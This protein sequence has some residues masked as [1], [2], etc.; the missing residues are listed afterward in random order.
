M[1]TDTDQVVAAL[2][3]SLLDNQ[4]LRQENRRLRDDSA[5]PVAVVAMSCRYPGGVRTPEDLWELLVKE[6]DAVSPFPTDRGWDV[7]GGFDADPDAPGTFYVREGG[8]LHD[9]TGFDPG[10]FGISPREALAMDPQQRLLLEASWEAVERAGIDPTTL[11]GSRTG[12]YTGVIY[13]EY[14]SRLDRVPD[15]VEGFLGTGSIPSVASGRIAYT[16]G[17]EGP[18]VT[19]DTAC[20]SSLVAVH[21]A[22]QGLRSGDT[23]LALAGGVTV[24]STPGL[25]V[26][27]SR[28]R[29][30]APDGRSKSFSSAADGAGFGEGLGLL[31]LERLSD[32][33]RAG[34]PVLAVIRGSA[35][36]QDGASNGLT[37]PNGPAQQRVISQALARAGLAPSEVDMV[38]AHGTGTVLGDPIEAQ[39]L[40]ATYGQDRPAGRPLWLG[41]LKSNLSHTQAAAG[42]GGVIKSVLAMRHGVMPRTLHVDRPS[43]RVDWTEGAVSLLTE[44]TPWPETGRPRRAGVSSFGASGTNAHVILEQAPIAPVVLEETPTAPTGATAAADKPVDRTDTPEPVPAAVPWILSARTPDALRAQAA[45][46]HERVVAEPGLSVVDVGHSLAVGRSRFAERAVV[47]GADR[48]E[49]LAGLAALSRGAGSAGVVTGGGPLPGR[50]VLVFPGHGSQWVGMAAGL[51]GESDVFAERMAECGRALAPYTDWSLAEALGSERLLA[52]VDVVQPVLWAVMVS[53]AEVWRAFGVVPDAVVGH[54]Q[55]EIAAA[56]V[57]GGLS[58][59]DGAR[60][61]AL[62]SRAV[63]ALAGR[64]GMASVPLPVDVVRERTAP[65]AG[66]LSVAAVNGPSSTVV[67]GAADAVTAL[68][69]ELLEEGV[70][71]APIDVDYASHSIHVEEIRERLLSDLEGITPLSGAVP[72]YSSVTGGPLDTKALDAGYWYRNLRQTVEFERATRSLLAAG[73][74]VFIES[75][76]QPALMYGIEDTAADAGAPETLVLDTLRRGAG[77][78]RRFQTALAEAHVRG[79]RVDWERLFAG[80]GARRVDLPTYAFQRRRYWLDALP[81]DRDPAATGQLA[82]DHPLLGAEVELPDDAGSLFTGRLSLATHPWLADHAVAGAVIVPGAALVE[83]AAYVGRRLGCALVEELT[84]AAPLSLPGDA[85][86]DH[87][88]HLRVR[89]GAE[90]GAGR[91]PVEFHSRPEAAPGAAAPP[92]TRHATGTVGPQEPSADGDDTAGP[93]GAWPPPDAVP[94]DVDELYGLLEARGVAYGPAFRGLRAAW[95][96]TDAIHAEVALPDDLPGTGADGFAMH[97]ALLDAAL[98][99]AGLREVAGTAQTA[100]GVPLPFSW[101]RVAIGTS[102]APVLR[103]RLRP[104]GPDTVAARITDPSG[105]TVATVGSLT[106]RTASTAALRA[107]SGSVFHVG[108]TPVTA[109]PGPRP[110]TRWGLL[111]PRDERLLPVAFPADLLPATPDAMLLPCPPSAGTGTTDGATGDTPARDADP[112]AA[113]VVVSGVLD[114]VQAHLA[115]DSTARTPLVVLTRGATGPLGARPQ[116]A[117]LG[118]AAVWGMLRAAQLEHPDRFVLLDT[119]GPDPD[120]LGDALADLLATGE[121][122]AALRGGVLYAPRLTRPSPTT[123][124]TAPATAAR[125]AGPFGPSEGTVLLSGGGA[126]AAVLARHLV[127]AHGV[128]HLLVLSRRG[129]DAPGIPELT[130][131]LAEAGAELTAVS[132]DVAD[133]QALA[134]ALAAVP[135]RHPLRAVVHTAGVLDDGLLDGL[136]A[137][138]MSAV[139]RPKLDAA[140]HLDQLTRG[141]DLSAFV[142]FS[143]AAA[144]LGSPG[145]ASYSA[146]NAALDALAAERRRLGLPGLSLAW[147]PWERVGGMT[148]EL[149]GAERRRIDRRGARGLVDEEAMALLDTVC[150]PDAAPPGDGSPVVL[151]HLDLTVRGDGPVHPMLRS[152]VR[153]GPAATTGAKGTPTAAAALRNRLDAAADAEEHE[154]VLREL[155]LAQ[156][157]EVLG[158]T[159]SGALSATVPFLSVGF[160]SLTAVELRNRLAA[161]TGL[162]LRPSA[163]FDSGTPAALAARLATEARTEDTPRP[164]TAPATGAASGTGTADTDPVSVLF[165]R[166]CALGRID[167]GIALLK[168]A[169][170]LRPSFHSGGD[171]AAAGTGPRLLRL[172]ERA[173]APVLVCFG[174]VVA[175]GGAHQ[176]AR[177]AS[178][179]RDRYAVAALDAPGFTPEEELPADM[180]A[181]LDF[182]ATTL[183]RELPGRTLV[184]V[185][186]SSGGTLAHGV[187]AALEQRG[188]GPAAV[189]LLDTYLSDNQGITQFNDVLLGGMFAREDRAAPMDGTRLTAMG[190]YFRLLDDWNPPEV[191]APLLLVRASTPLGR[192][193]AEAGDWRSSWAGADAVVDVPGDHFSIMEQHVATTG[194]AVADWLGTTLRTSDD[195]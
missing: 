138:R 111:G 61:V 115:D 48:G 12:V 170:A 14:A 84:L 160:D 39:A 98:Q 68:V 154:L 146:A 176:Y 175:L 58:L 186:S 25:Y 101:Q 33:R 192:P 4:R 128:R 183:L 3:A 191:R 22:C 104:D 5:E 74:R 7:E 37:A 29:G 108:W 117:D 76:P 30:L 45:V 13:G 103:V 85:A 57:A 193:S 119:E 21:L 133:R 54:S 73:H 62:R 16:L 41:S 81:A 194:D 136:T 149:G 124:A 177:F 46:L 143:S 151:A 140:R 134:A 60:V 71:A 35:V 163:V 66:R 63:G 139:L 162:R 44:A 6:R 157:A 153:R 167:E 56:C 99:T 53:L 70:W 179:F 159:D 65:W 89:V 27:F 38:E 166:A 55:G 43:P 131:E 109:G 36:N 15:E 156:A 11:R 142:V 93:A 83:L 152:L 51:L 178:R 59:D 97:P 127:A 165:R 28:Q 122:Q 184:L 137:E 72:Y 118:A 88:V 195:L 107:S 182:Q 2:R 9:A 105:R 168:H 116:P 79:L 42:V 144:V 102:D 110:V 190:G 86:D 173:D 52:R 17:L 24:M 112:E 129:A 82:V 18:A 19:L 34:H 147:G 10:F 187:A 164:E 181:L 141:A 64:G 158:H 95:R 87:A 114:R 1:P 125:S 94:L 123:A 188:G 148:A 180:P 78:L 130:A 171:L 32:A 80:T 121:P 174:S 91:R 90:D 172:N 113:H 75:S 155:V 77:G 50:S 150:A 40:L 20:S 161:V 106:L 169:S 100:D 67:S 8:F 145:Q 135:E 132:C 47:V 92:W 96:T 69:G 23:T 120:G 185:G 189:V 126:L 49:L 26:G 31:L